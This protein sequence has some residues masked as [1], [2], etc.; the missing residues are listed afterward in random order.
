MESELAWSS[1]WQGTGIM[2]FV[3]VLFSAEGVGG[4]RTDERLTKT[5][6]SRSQAQ[7]FCGQKRSLGRKIQISLDS[8]IAPAVKGAFV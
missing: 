5:E 4:A 1:H 2:K 7:P 8:V 3:C 6:Q